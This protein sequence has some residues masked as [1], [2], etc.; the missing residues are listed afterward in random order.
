M[1][2][3]RLR[4]AAVDRLVQPALG[5]ERMGCLMQLSSIRFL[6]PLAAAVVIASGC[7][8]SERC[9]LL[10]PDQK[11]YRLYLKSQH[12]EAAATFA[13][14]RWRGVALFKQGEFKAAAAIFSGI[15][16]AE[17]TFNHG[18]ALVMS[19]QYEDAVARYDRAL[20]LQ[21]GWQ[22]AIV[23]REIAVASAQRLK[24]EGGEMTGGMLE[25]DDIVF[26]KGKSPPGSAEEVV[27][28]N[29]QY[30]EAEMQ[31]LW[32]RQVQTRPADFLRSKFAYQYAMEQNEKEEGQ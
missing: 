18:N 16:T 12:K 13:D 30:N 4:A 27:D 26:S 20:E 25:A 24:L 15:D 23:N 32:L 5:K 3:W 22:D 17:G 7:L 28:E 9:A 14:P 2:G 29:S 19:G 8:L 21:P 1:E 10:K 6:I 11:G 31:A